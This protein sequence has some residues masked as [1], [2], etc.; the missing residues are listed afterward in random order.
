MF[1]GSG[2]ILTFLSRLLLVS[3]IMFVTIN[4]VGKQ[5]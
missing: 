1:L 4:H 2:N 5:E 3:Y